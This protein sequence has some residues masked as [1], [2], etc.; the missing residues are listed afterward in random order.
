MFNIKMY[1]KGSLDEKFKLVA[2]TIRAYPAQLKQ[3]WEEIR[4]LYIPDDYKNIENIVFCG[5]GGSAL[6]ARVVDSFSFN[7]LRV[8]F[9]IFNDYK[10]P[11]YVNHKTLVIVSSYS[12]NTEETIQSTYSAIKKNAKVFGITTGGKLAE[13]LKNEKIPAYIFEPRNNPSK[14]PRMS[15]GYASGAVLALLERLGIITLTYE[16]IET[17]ISVMNNTLTEY[18]EG[19]ASDKNL[20]Y[21]FAK[22]LKG[23]IPILIASEHLVG[24]S[25]AIKNQFN[26]SAKTFS[27]NFDIPELNHH[28][29]EGLRNPNQAKEKLCFV[30]FM[31]NLY[32][33]RVQKRYPLTVE[34]VEKNSISTEIFAPRSY[35]KLSQVYEVLIFG[36]FVVYFLTKEYLIDPMEIPWVDYFKKKLSSF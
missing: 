2:D 8:P 35:D 25:Y 13:I 28:L 20:A 34:V 9:E 27:V 24:V 21:L 22:K 16:S 6:G 14:Q 36:S 3:S 33:E 12:G 26:E 18:N 29:M 23:K 1:N 5:M 32:S 15:I 31:S 4:N 7:H 11:K 17:T 30:F 10:L 19:V